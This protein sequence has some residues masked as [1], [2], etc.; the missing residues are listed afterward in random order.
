M[1]SNDMSDE[2]SCLVRVYSYS[3]ML[4]SASVHV[5]DCAYLHSCTLIIH[6]TL[7]VLYLLSVV[8]YIMSAY[9]YYYTGRLEE[10]KDRR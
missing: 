10:S 4:T 6:A 5:H 1:I 8:F 3:L 9:T 2:N 7:T